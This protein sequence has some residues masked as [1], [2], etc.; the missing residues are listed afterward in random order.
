MKLKT[1]LLVL[2]SL[3]TMG[4]SAQKFKPASPTFLKGES[5]INLVFDYSQLKFNGTSQEDFYKKKDAKWIKE[6]EGQRRENNAHGFTTH[7]IK[8]LNKI[9]V[10][11][12][13]Y[14]KAQYTVIVHVDDCFFGAFAGPRTFPAKLQC[15]VDVVKTGTTEPLATVTIKVSNSGWHS[16]NDF[17]RIYSAFMEMGAEVAGLLLKALE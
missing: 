16:P 10:D 5:Q 14:P 6:W 3:A 4:A 11:L 17:D 7:S 1:L 8:W 15:T 13:K 12:D 2:L 9:N